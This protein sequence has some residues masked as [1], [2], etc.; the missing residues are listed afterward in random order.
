MPKNCDEKFLVFDQSD[1][2]GTSGNVVALWCVASCTKTRRPMKVLLMSVFVPVLVIC[3]G[4]GPV[5]IEVLLGLIN[6]DAHRISLTAMI[7]HLFV[8]SIM[9]QSELANIAVIAVLRYAVRANSCLEIT[10]N[11]FLLLCFL[12]PSL[13]SL[14][15]SRG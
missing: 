1:L 3:V 9:A 13:Y 11:I 10:L 7:T 8:Y 2:L 6:C 4:T 15:W 14:V 12:I 5:V